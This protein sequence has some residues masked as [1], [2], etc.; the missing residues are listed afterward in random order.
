[1]ID[2]SVGERP[3]DLLVLVNPEIV[4][5]EGEQEVEEGCLSLPEFTESVRRPGIVE[6]PFSSTTCSS[7]SSGSSTRWI[8]SPAASMCSSCGCEAS[9]P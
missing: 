3:A 4:G 8:G 1:V 6:A 7:T 2:T 9:L 5:E